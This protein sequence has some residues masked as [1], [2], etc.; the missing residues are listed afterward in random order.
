MYSLIRTNKLEKTTQDLENENLY[1]KTIT[2]LYDNIIDFRHNFNNIIQSL[3]GYIADNNMD[4]LKTYFNDVLD[5]SQISNNLAT[6]NPELINNPAVYSIL[7]S[8]YYQADE[9]GIK[10]NFEIFMDLA[11]L[12]IKTYD[13]S[14]ILGILLDN[15]IDASKNSKEKKIN[16]IIRKDHKV[17]RQLFIIENTY[18]N[19]DVDLDRIFE[20]GYTSKETQDDQSHGLGL[21]NIR[22][23]LK[24]NK[25]LNLFTSKT[26]ELFNQQLEIYS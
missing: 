8:K 4:G 19:K 3:D 23:I 1:N 11:N 15:A 25:N 14:L 10:M 16:V 26:E 12:K 13:L 18:S 6:L 24:K 9:L 20:K 5:V 7:S 2:V 22:K 17:N 21:W